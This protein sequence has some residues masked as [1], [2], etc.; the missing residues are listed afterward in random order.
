M[1]SKKEL[2]LFIGLAFLVLTGCSTGNSRHDVNADTAAKA[3]FMSSGDTVVE[4]YDNGYV[5]S[6]SNKQ[7]R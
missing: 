6:I 4:Y 3:T 1:L 2:V 5:K 7:C